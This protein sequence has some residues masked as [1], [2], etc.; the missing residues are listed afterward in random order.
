MTS[1]W[2]L[3]NAVLLGAFLLR[4]RSLRLLGTAEAATIGAGCMLIFFFSVG[5][6]HE[7]ARFVIAV[8]PLLAALPRVF[9]LD[10]AETRL[11]VTLRPRPLDMPFRGDEHGRE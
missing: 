8:L 5:D 9:R 4:D 7:E 2:L 10:L 1:G 6:V 11:R 3:L